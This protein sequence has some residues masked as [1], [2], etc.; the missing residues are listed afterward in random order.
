MRQSTGQTVG[1]D[2]SDE[3]RHPGRHAC[4]WNA[5]PG[6]S[7]CRRPDGEYP[8]R[9]VPAG[10]FPHEGIRTRAPAPVLPLH[11]AQA[12]PPTSPCTSGRR[13]FKSS[14]A[15]SG[16]GQVTRCWT[17]ERQ[18]WVAGRNPQL[19]RTILSLSAERNGCGGQKTFRSAVAVSRHAFHPNRGG[20][21]VRPF[22]IRSSDL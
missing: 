4:R 15:C 22:G 9:G 16:P 1:S 19:L 18:R 2:S 21:A 3:V 17:S 11:S 13:S 20:S 12:V 5:G 6:P 8:P 10:T 14:W 7:A